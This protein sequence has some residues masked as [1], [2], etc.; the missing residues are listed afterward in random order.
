MST[1][2][3]CQYF[4]RSNRWISSTSSTQGHKTHRH[5]I[6]TI[7]SSSASKVSSA[8]WGNWLKL[9]AFVNST[10]WWRCRVLGEY[11][12]PST[13][14]IPITSSVRSSGVKKWTGAGEEISKERG[15]EFEEGICLFYFVLFFTFLPLSFRFSLLLLFFTFFFFSLYTW[16][17]RY[18]YSAINQTSF[19]KC[20]GHQSCGKV[21]KERPRA[22]APRMHR[23]KCWPW[24]A[25]QEGKHAEVEKKQHRPAG[26]QNILKSTSRTQLQKFSKNPL[27][28]TTFLNTKRRV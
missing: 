16:F 12:R 22:R 26:Q 25:K 2:C 20:Y 4:K 18:F 15:I 17:F 13:A 1:S 10:A 14:K 19:D 21:T 3:N 6:A 9:S 28:H 23:S 8:W 7:R 11:L 5:L 24:T 27:K